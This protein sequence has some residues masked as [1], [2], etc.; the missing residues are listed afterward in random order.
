MATKAQLLVTIEALRSENEVLR[1]QIGD[2]RAS[3][4]QK[5]IRTSAVRL[6]MQRA[7][8]EA[9]RTGKTVRVTH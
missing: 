5:T 9:M 4:I 1:T 3:M 7:R 2:L 6:A 8:D